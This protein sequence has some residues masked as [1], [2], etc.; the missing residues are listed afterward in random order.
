MLKIISKFLWSSRNPDGK[1]SY[2]KISQNRIEQDFTQGGLKFS[3][4]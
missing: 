2:S 4:T 1:I 3:L